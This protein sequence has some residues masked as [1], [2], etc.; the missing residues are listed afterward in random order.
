ME[1]IITIVLA[2]VPAIALLT[3]PRAAVRGTALATGVL[4]LLRS[5]ENEPAGNWQ[6]ALLDGVASTY[7]MKL[8]KEVG[9]LAG[10]GVDNSGE[11][12]SIMV[13][14]GGEGVSDEFGYPERFRGRRVGLVVSGDVVYNQTHMWLAGSTPDSRASWSRARRTTATSCLPKTSAPRASC[15]H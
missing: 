9:H 3:V 13:A 11:P 4:V 12:R 7:C 14:K 2:F 8:S 5:K 1:F 10:L 15:R 6:L